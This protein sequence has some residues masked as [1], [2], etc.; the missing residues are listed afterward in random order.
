M[1]IKGERPNWVSMSPSG[2]YCV[3]SNYGGP[4]VVAYSRDFSTSKKIADIGE[5]SD[6]GIDAAGDDAYVSIDYNDA[7]GNVYMANLRTGVRTNLFP[8]YVNGTSTAFH[9]SGKNF[10][11]PGWFVMS[12]YAESGR[13]QWLHRKV[14]VVQMAANPK[15]YNLA[16]TSNNYAGY[17]SAPVASTNRD[18]TRVV[19]NSNWGTGSDTDVDTYMVQ[20]LPD[21]IR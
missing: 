14:A 8:S 21:S 16:Q 5:H 12:T 17:W 7:G 20:M 10:N 1:D 11:K 4:G 3:T 18:L 9:F 2:N 15:I 6:I 19:W 13:Q